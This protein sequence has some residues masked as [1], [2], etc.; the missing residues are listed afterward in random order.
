M[1][2]ILP[3]VTLITD[4]GD[5]DSYV[6]AM[7][8]VLLSILPDARI[9]DVTHQV[10]PQN[11]RQAAATLSEVYPFFPAHTV[12]LVIV[13]PGVGS[14]RDPI[15][16]ETT[17]G[18]FVAPDNGVLTYVL[19]NEPGWKA[20][21][22]DKSDFWRAQSPSNTFHGRDIFSS[23]AAHLAGGTPLEQLGSTIDN[24]TQISVSSVAI[25]GNMIK[26]EVV[27]ID[28]FGNVITNIGDLRW[29]SDDVLELH[30]PEQSS[31]LRI[32][33]KKAHVIVSW[34]TLDGIY[35]MYSAVGPGHRLAL[36]GSGGELEIA[37]NQ[38]NAAD[39]MNIKPGDPVSIRVS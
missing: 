10:E 24:L 25:N 19:Q 13:D 22:L 30:R 18:K 38:G 8:G 31:P 14:T 4:F 15:A 26:G 37:V 21:R 20:V 28:H 9:V 35:P 6:G 5:R 23:V 29:A 33:A 27:H 7:K 34:H 32:D 3:I 36:V 2:S 1:A 39:S 11:I 16:V 17:R 12:H